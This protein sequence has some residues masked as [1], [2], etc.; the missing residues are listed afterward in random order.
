MPN[1]IKEAM[2]S[3]GVTVS[4][5][6]EPGLTK[7]ILISSLNFAVSGFSMNKNVEK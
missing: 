4:E 2:F 6:S 7:L 5:V 3:A 1:L